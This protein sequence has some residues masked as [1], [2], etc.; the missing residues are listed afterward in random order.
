MAKRRPRDIGTAF[1]TQVRKLFSPLWPGLRRTETTA[2]YGDAP[3]FTDDTGYC[4][5]AIEA[6]ASQKRELNPWW[7]QTTA[8]AEKR[9]GLPLLVMRRHGVPANPFCLT[10]W[11]S[12]R[13]RELYVQALEERLRQTE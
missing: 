5:W 12:R 13:A 7:Q 1:E 9:D 4:P 3:D 2:R 6:K 10:D 11:D 8:S